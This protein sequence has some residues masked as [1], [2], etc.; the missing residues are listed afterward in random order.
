MDKY[1]NYQ[2]GNESMRVD[3]RFAITLTDNGEQDEDRCCL[4]AAPAID[5]AP[6]QVAVYVTGNVDPAQILTLG[7]EGE[8]VWYLGEDEPK[9]TEATTI[10]DVLETFD[11][12]IGLTPSACAEKCAELFEYTVLE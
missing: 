11:Q 10:A 3:A 7:C 5:G 1:Y 4:K 6:G 9:E 12:F 8:I 2:V